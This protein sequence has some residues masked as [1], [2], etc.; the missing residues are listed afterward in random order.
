MNKQQIL[1]EIRRSAQANGGCPLGRQA[2]AKETGI[3]VSDW[4]GK[5]WSRWG[6]AL[7]EA[8]FVPNEL[9]RPL[10][11]E[12]LICKLIEFM[13]ELQPPRFPVAADLR[14]KARSTPGF[15]SHNAFERLG[16][17]S[18]RVAKIAAHCTAAGGFD[19]IIALCRTVQPPKN[20]PREKP[21]VEDQFGF[22]YL[23]RSGRNYKIGRSNSTG[24]RE[25]E[26]AIQLP[27][28]AVLVHE[29][30]TDDPSGI[31]AYWHHRFHSKRKNGEWFALEPE[32]VAAFKRRPF[33]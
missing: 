2:F 20:P 6:D 31:E 16:T 23:L 32:D 1:H 15:P 25:Y 14:I 12:F 18:E 28:R 7:K 24:R 8:G 27:D 10:D 13:R 9:Q 3:R 19:D 11:D 29:I 17:K 4:Y 30:R 22:V 26:L 33:M 5:H 21:T